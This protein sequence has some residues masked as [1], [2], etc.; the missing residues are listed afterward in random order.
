MNYTYVLDTAPFPR[1]CL[2]S[3]FNIYHTVLANVDLSTKF[4]SSRLSD[5]SDAYVHALMARYPRARY[6]VGSDAKYFMILTILPEWLSDLIM[7][8]VA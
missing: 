5:V 6:V 1:L 8:K 2:I 7:S 3:H 4:A